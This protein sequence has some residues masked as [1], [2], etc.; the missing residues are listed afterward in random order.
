MA[1]KSGFS[2]VELTVVIGL[3]ALL[4]MAISAI[5]LT[6]IVS[7][8]RIR[9]LT[10]IK[11][12][13]DYTVNQLETLIRNSRSISVCDSTNNTSTISNPD[14][15]STTIYLQADQSGV[16]RVAS[17]SGTF[18][19]PPDLLVTNYKLTCAPNDIS[20]RLVTISFDMSPLVAS[21]K[22]VENGTLHFQTSVELRNNLF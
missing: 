1:V 22:A 10:K 9:T 4:A 21:V 2:L 8:N 17:G 5:M 3:I 15:G 20:P 18:L 11:Q 7:S 19:T 12:A 13:G 6:T 16:N 14:G